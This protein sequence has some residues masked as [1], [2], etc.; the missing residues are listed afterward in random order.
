MS[1]VTSSNPVSDLPGPSGYK[2]HDW[3]T[4]SGDSGAEDLDPEEVIMHIYKL[5]KS[6]DKKLDMMTS[7]SSATS[8]TLGRTVQSLVGVSGKVDKI[9]PQVSGIQT[10]VSELTE[11]LD[12]IGKQM[13]ALSQAAPNAEPENATPPENSTPE[14]YGEATQGGRRRRRTVKKGKKSRK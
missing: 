13:N 8:T 10:Q 11:S 7:N 12:T 2:G 4:Q 1:T 6:V 5:L 9:T 14:G 3:Q